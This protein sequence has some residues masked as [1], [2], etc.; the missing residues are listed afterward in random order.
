MAFERKPLPARQGGRGRPR[1]ALRR[2]TVPGMT[3]PTP[4]IALRSIPAAVTSWSTPRT[5]SGTAL[6]GSRRVDRDVDLADDGADEID[7][8]ADEDPMVELEAECVGDLGIDRELDR[9]LPG[10][11]TAPSGGAHQPG[12]LEFPG[13]Y[14][15]SSAASARSGALSPPGSR[16]RAG[17]RPR[18]RPRRFVGASIFEI[19]PGETHAENPRRA[20]ER[21]ACTVPRGNK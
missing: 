19:G 16:D 21:A 4:Q 1:S 9:R 5:I 14:W 6:V 12:A 7:Q 11:G 8:H 17:A 15:R 20:S 3:T 2:R 18:A 13:R 10:R